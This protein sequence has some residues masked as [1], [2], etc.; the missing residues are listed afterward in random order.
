MLYRRITE[1]STPGCGHQ[2][3]MRFGIFNFAEQNHILAFANATEMVFLLDIDRINAYE[4]FYQEVE[5]WDE[6]AG[7]VN[8]TQVVA[9]GYPT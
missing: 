5:S 6:S 3:F 8:P 7:P 2:F 4:D 1:F 9:A